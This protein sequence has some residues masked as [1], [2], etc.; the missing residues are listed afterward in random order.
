MDNCWRNAGGA[1]GATPPSLEGYGSMGLEGLRV[2]HIE[3][4]LLM[5]LVERV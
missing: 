1:L 3:L 2:V 4:E 5:A